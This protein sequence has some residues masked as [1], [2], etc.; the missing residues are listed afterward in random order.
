MKILNFIIIFVTIFLSGCGCDECFAQELIASYYST[1][2]LIKEG[3]WKNGERMMAN[4]RQFSDYGLTAA[5]N[6]FP[7]GTKVR[8]TNPVTKAYVCVSIT[9][10]TAKM[11]KGKRIDLSKRAMFVLGGQ[12]AIDKGL[13]KVDVEKIN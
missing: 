10:R 9:D 13:I 3:T 2:S 11:F 8:V 4:G 5:C 6:S 12:W 1:S 7:L